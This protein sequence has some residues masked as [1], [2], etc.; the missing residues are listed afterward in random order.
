MQ[1]IFSYPSPYILLVD[2]VQHLG[3]GP[4]HDLVF[5]G[6]KTDRTQSSG[7]ST[8]PRFTGFAR[9]APVSADRKI[10]R[11]NSRELLP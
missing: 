6:W 3:Y 2:G 1:F 4:L 5:Q 7:F 9:Y 8:L 11:R 10:L